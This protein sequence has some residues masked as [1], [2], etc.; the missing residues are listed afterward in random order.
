MRMLSG[1]GKPKSASWLERERA[2]HSDGGDQGRPVQGER[3]AIISQNSPQTTP[4][5]DAMRCR[6]VTAQHPDDLNLLDASA[7]H[8][9][10]RR[11]LA[12]TTPTVHSGWGARAHHEHAA[13]LTDSTRAASPAATKEPGAPRH[14]EAAAGARLQT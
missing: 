10:R 4:L 14:V 7:A 3:N 12:V 9:L 2:R 13:Q 11:P 6:S 8:T 5:C 1:S